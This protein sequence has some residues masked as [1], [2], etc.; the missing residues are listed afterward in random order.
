MIRNAL[1]EQ[2]MVRDENDRRR[3]EGLSK[4]TETR[5]LLGREGQGRPSRYRFVQTSRCNLGRLLDFL[6]REVSSRDHLLLQIAELFPS[7]RL[8]CFLVR[9]RVICHVVRR[10]P[11]IMNLSGNRIETT[12]V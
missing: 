2:G 12:S 4:L 9:P 10:G 5:D 1:E 6:P 3:R 8:P 7:S 11:A